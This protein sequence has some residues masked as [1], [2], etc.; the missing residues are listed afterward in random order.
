[1]KRLLIDGTMPRSKES[2]SSSVDFKKVI[3]YDV[4]HSLK[5][6]WHFLFVF[7]LFYIF[8]CELH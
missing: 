7:H 2:I 8:K 1:M 3:A 4:D 5:A 6:S